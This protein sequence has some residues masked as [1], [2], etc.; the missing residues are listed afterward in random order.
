MTGRQTFTLILAVLSPLAARALAPVSRHAAAAAAGNNADPRRQPLP[1]SSSAYAVDLT[2][3]LD[4]SAPT[5]ENGAPLEMS[6]ETVDDG[7]GGRYCTRSTTFF[8]ASTR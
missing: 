8:F 2:H 3:T 7:V 6:K 4:H 5:E 1:G